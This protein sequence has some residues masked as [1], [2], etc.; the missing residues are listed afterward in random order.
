MIISSNIDN[1]TCFYV[2]FLF[3]NRLPMP[4]R[5]EHNQTNYVDSLRFYKSKNGCLIFNSNSTL[6]FDI[7]IH[8][9]L[10]FTCICTNFIFHKLIITY[11]MEDCSCLYVPFWSFT[12]CLFGNL[13]LMIQIIILIE[14]T[15]LDNLTHCTTYIVWGN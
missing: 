5:L 12:S 11:F 3:L 15:I 13:L 9:R 14:T 2:T 7:V 4:P 10:L 6:V 8:F 1:C